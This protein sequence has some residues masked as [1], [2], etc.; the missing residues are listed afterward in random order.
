MTVHIV[1]MVHTTFLTEEY[2]QQHVMFATRYDAT[3]KCVDEKGKMNAIA[4]TCSLSPKYNHRLPFHR[5]LYLHSLLHI[6][7]K[8]KAWESREFLTRD[9]I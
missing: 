3:Q 6:H 2:T 1:L 5:L 9:L 7:A 4:V 8:S